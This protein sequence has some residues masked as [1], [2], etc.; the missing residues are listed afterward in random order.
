MEAVLVEAE[1]LACESHLA[2]G[3]RGTASLNRAHGIL[4]RSKIEHIL[5]LLLITLATTPEDASDCS[6]A[7]PNNTE[8]CTGAA[9]TNNQR[10]D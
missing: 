8:P 3:M 6:G 10:S 1:C 5:I 7:R 9:Y 2:R 4:L